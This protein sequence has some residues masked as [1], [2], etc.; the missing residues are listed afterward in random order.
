MRAV[1]ARVRSRSIRR[2]GTKVFQSTDGDGGGVR[3]AFLR[4]RR[5]HAFQPT[6]DRFGNGAVHVETAARAGVVRRGIHENAHARGPRRGFRGGGAIRPGSRPGVANIRPG[7][8]PGVANIRPGSRPGV[9]VRDSLRHGFLLRP[10]FFLRALVALVPDSSARP[11]VSR[12]RF[13][14][15]HLRQSRPSRG[16]GGS[17]GVHP[18]ASSGGSPRIRAAPKQRR[19][20]RRVPSPRRRGQRRHAVLVRRVHVHARAHRREH[21]PRVVLRGGGEKRLDAFR[22]RLAEVGARASAGTRRAEPPITLRFLFSAR[23]LDGTREPSSSGRVG[24]FKRGEAFG[25]FMKERFTRVR[26]KERFTRVRIDVGIGVGHRGIVA[27]VLLDGAARRARPLGGARRTSRARVM[28]SAN[29]APPRATFGLAMAATV[30]ERRGGGIPSRRGGGI[31]N[32]RMVVRYVRVVGGV[33]DDRAA[34]RLRRDDDEPGCLGRTH[35]GEERADVARERVRVDIVRVG[36]CA[37]W[38]ARSPPTA[39]W[40]RSSPRSKGHA[41]ARTSWQT[42]SSRRRSAASWMSVMPRRS[43]HPRARASHAGVGTGSSRRSLL[44]FTTPK[45]ATDPWSTASTNARVSASVGAR[46]FTSR[47]SF[48]AWYAFRRARARRFS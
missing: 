25:G 35:A 6:K 15:E 8:R 28:V 42:M 4:R 12:S 10:G 39:S 29:E 13:V 45:R 27:L 17:R 37:S 36:G 1:G 19:R 3:V 34:A 11:L 7:S 38:V 40:S 44:S 2:V 46:R 31:P 24:E 48:S 14:L 43:V 20:R 23:R 18:L 33:G 26:M 32:R 47:P 22:T 30:Q 21:A 41:P 9:A 16:S 5:A